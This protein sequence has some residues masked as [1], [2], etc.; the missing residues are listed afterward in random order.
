MERISR[1]A[2][3]IAKRRPIHLLFILLV[4]A[5]AVVLGWGVWDAIAHGLRWE[6][7]PYDWFRLLRI[8]IGA[9]GLAASLVYYIRWNDAWSREHA[10]EEFRLKRLDLDI[11]R[12]SW[13]VEMMLEWKE[14]KDS[15]IPPELI[16]RLS[17]NLFA[18]DGRETRPVQHPAQDLTALLL[19]A[20]SVT[21]PVL[22]GSATIDAKG[23]RKLQKSVKDGDQG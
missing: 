5:P 22:G 13:M 23:L 3:T 7:T 12:A 11:D 19:Q 17:R 4:G 2:N 16:D 14:E 20:S 8:P 15:P 18:G 1:L 9:L 10:D 6:G 21:I